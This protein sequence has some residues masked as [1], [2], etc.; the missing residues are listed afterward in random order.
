M[1]RADQ[2]KANTK[3]TVLPTSSVGGGYGATAVAVLDCGED[4]EKSAERNGV[5]PKRNSTLHLRG[6]T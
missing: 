3:G 5:R 1:E 4:M 2:S 6:K